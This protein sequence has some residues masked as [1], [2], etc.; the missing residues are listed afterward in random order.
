[1]NSLHVLEHE[2]ASA[3]GIGGR[4]HWNGIREAE[5]DW[6]AGALLVPRASALAWLRC[7]DNYNAGARHFGFSLELFTWRAHMGAARQIGYA[8]ARQRCAARWRHP[9]QPDPAPHR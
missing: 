7:S 8:R 9:R 5:A 4:R 1:M 3:I 2:P 6:L